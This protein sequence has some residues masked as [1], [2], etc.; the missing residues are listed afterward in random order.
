MQKIQ[1][2]LLA[3]ECNVDGELAQPLIA[4]YAAMR[5]ESER[6]TM[7]LALGEAL[8]HNEDV[9]LCLSVD[10]YK[11]VLNFLLRAFAH[12][13]GILERQ[14]MGGQQEQNEVTMHS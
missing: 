8:S 9:L 5:T 10:V 11:A 1:E 12:E 4:H 2:L 3:V 13:K 7:I 14:S 6:M